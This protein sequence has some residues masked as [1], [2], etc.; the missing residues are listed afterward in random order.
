MG[1]ANNSYRIGWALLAV[2]S[3]AALVW[4]G[5]GLFP[6]WPLMWFAPLPILL[7]AARS[8]WPAAAAAAMLAWALGNLNQWHYFRD[9]LHVPLTVCAMV[10][11]APACMFALTVLLFRALARRNGNLSRRGRDL[12]HRRRCAFARVLRERRHRE[13]C[14]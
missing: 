2:L 9:V 14:G 8:A 7:F 12:G 11:L 3:T 4:F 1:F 10:V 13:L 5:T 6:L